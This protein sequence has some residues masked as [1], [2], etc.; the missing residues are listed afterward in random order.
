MKKL[1][2]VEPKKCV[3]IDAPIPEINDDQILVKIKYYGVCMSEHTAWE[4][5]ETGNGVDEGMGHEP[6]GYVEKVGKNITKVKPGDRVTGLFGQGIAEYNVATEDRVFKIPD[7]IADEYAVG[8]P[9]ACMLSA[10]SKCRN[11]F[12][13]E[14]SIGVVG[15][16]YM[17][18]AIISLLKLRGA[19]RIV[20]VDINEESRKNA[21]MYGAD[22][23]Y[24]P[25]EVPDKYLAPR[26]RPTSGGLDIVYEW[27]ETN[28]SL[29]LAIRMTKMC[30]QL[31]I[32][33]YHTG[34]KRLVDI[35]LCGVKAIDML[36]THPRELDLHQKGCQ[37]ALDMLSSGKWNYQ[38]FPVKIYPMN[39]FDD[40]HEDITKK[41]GIYMK[42]LIDCTVFDGEPYIKG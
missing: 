23:V 24:S 30:G 14:T 34:D 4:I 36:N 9:L 12:P 6:M 41:Y 26:E 7:N 18:C 25:D 39:K 5:A 2:V 40:A 17:G 27:A 20:A 21:L 35:Q 33:A 13:G 31:C 28:E 29:D 1:A 8:E 16:G 42:S 32:G 15:C 38:G 11:I 10:V 19:G 22:E 37:N 3:L